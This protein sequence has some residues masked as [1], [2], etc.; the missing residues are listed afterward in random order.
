MVDQSDDSWSFPARL[1]AGQKWRVEAEAMGRGITAALVDIG[2]IENGMSVLDIASGEGDPALTLAQL[3][4]QR[5]TITATDINLRP[6]ETAAA[7]ARELGLSNV[8]FQVAD[9]E[10]LPFPD[11]FVDRVTCRCGLMFFPDAVVAMRE[12]LRVLKPGGR[13]A[14]VAWGT[15]QQPYFQ[16]FLQPLLRHAPG[17]VLPADGPNPFKFAGAGSLSS[18]LREAGFR[19]VEEKAKT[20]ERVWPGSPE[21]AWQYFRDHAA[22]FRPLIERVPASKREVVT[23]EILAGIS[24]FR[25]SGGYDLQAQII[26]G[27]ATK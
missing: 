8:S 15:I 18:L 5:G 22:P 4:G 9:A 14:L 20:V 11:A 2:R 6:L 24:A 12:A 16:V 7:R 26:L 23:S 19:D 25:V 3:V 21:D 13:V 1:A 27:T 10:R 17:P